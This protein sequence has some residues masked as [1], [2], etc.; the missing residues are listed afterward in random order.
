MELTT[1]AY[2]ANHTSTPLLQPYH[3]YSLPPDLHPPPTNPSCLHTRLTTPRR[4]DPVN[5]P[6]LLAHQWGW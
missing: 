6:D 1:H 3:P 2:H 4:I 5:A